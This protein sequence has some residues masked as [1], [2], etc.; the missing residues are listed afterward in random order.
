M[1][2]TFLS[3]SIE[4]AFVQLQ[5]IAVLFDHLF[6]KNECLEMA[7]IALRKLLMALGTEH[8]QTTNTSSD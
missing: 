7:N 8:V 6:L 1:T 5:K 4:F 3:E 2:W